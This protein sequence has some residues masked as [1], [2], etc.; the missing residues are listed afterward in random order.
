[1]GE[2]A[3]LKSW[4]THDPAH[5]GRLSPEDPEVRRLIRR[6]AAGSH[7]T[8]LGGW[9]SLNLRL[10]PAGIV[11]RVHQPFV[12]RRRL[13]VVQ[14]VR[15]RLA[16]AGLIVPLA[17]PWRG[18]TVLRCRR[19]LAEMEPYL[20]HDRRKPSLDTYVW[21]F[22]ALGEL[23]R[24]MAPLKLAVSRPVLA[25][26]TPPSTLRRWLAATSA[27]VAKDAEGSAV[28]NEL[29]G[30]VKKVAAAWVPAAR[31]P[32]Q[33]IHGDI[34]LANV[35]V[36]PSG[37]P[38]YLDFGNMSL[39]PR[40]HDLAY[41]FAHMVFAV[42]GYRK[43][44]LQA[45]PWHELPR[46]VHAYEAGAGWRLT[47]LEKHALVPYIA[48]V[49]VH[50]AARAGFFADPLAVLRSERPCLELSRWILTHPDHL[51]LSP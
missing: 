31:L 38:S 47:E 41:A 45:V 5:P 32:G 20:Q 26:Y 8:D 6:I 23:H 4:F 33:L 25:S 27:A 36:A 9:V 40:V 30:L 34:H 10:E 39:A 42:N 2:Y 51:G 28:T 48:A 1:M 43:L 3:R 11:L 21:L 46:L 49:P 35:G 13:R 12:S 37:R 14:H 24:A 17:V 29:H 50:Y 19:H 15:E 22:G 7:A 18:S 16:A 44:D